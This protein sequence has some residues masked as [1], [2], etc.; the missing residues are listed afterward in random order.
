MRIFSLRFTNT[1]DYPTKPICFHGHRLLNQLTSHVGHC[2]KSIPTHRIR[3]ATIFT[4]LFRYLKWRNPHLYKQYGYGLCKGKPTPKIAENKACLLIHLQSFFL[5]QAITASLVLR[6]VWEIH[7]CIIW[8]RVDQLL[9]LGIG[10]LQP[11][12]TGILISWVYKPLRNWV[13]EFILITW[14]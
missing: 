10:D 3:F 13:D 7:Q 1:L 2:F 6:S 12:M 8:T 11:L 5:Q 4:K 9:V 14:K